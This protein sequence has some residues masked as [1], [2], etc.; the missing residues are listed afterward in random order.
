[1]HVPRLSLSALSQQLSAISALP[2]PSH[3]FD[4]RWE[5]VPVFR[6]LLGQ[7]RYPE[8]NLLF[9]HHLLSFC[10]INEVP[11]AIRYAVAG[12]QEA[13]RSYDGTPHVDWEDALVAAPRGVSRTTEED[14]R[15]ESAQL[16]PVLSRTTFRLFQMHFEDVMA[17][18]FF[19]PQ[20]LKEFLSYHL[21]KQPKNFE[22]LI[23]IAALAY[24]FR[25]FSYRTIEGASA[26]DLFD[27]YESLM[28]AALQY[29]L[30]RDLSSLSLLELSQEYR[31]ID[32]L[33]YF[34]TMRLRTLC[35]LVLPDAGKGPLEK[36]LNDGA[37]LGEAIERC[38]SEITGNQEGDRN[39]QATYDFLRSFGYVSRL[40]SLGHYFERLKND[41]FSR[42]KKVP[43]KSFVQALHQT[44]LFMSRWLM[45]MI[46]NLP[47][48]LEWRDSDLEETIDWGTVRQ[49]Y[50][51]MQYEYSQ[52]LYDWYRDLFYAMPLEPED[53][54]MDLGSGYG[55]LA[56][57]AAI[58][59]PANVIG[60]EILPQRLEVA[61]RAAAALDLGRITFLQ[62]N[63]L[64]ADLQAANVFCLFSS[65]DPQTL[66]DM[67]ERLR[68]ESQRRKGH[69][70]RPMRIVSI[71]NS[72]YF[73]AS[74][75]WLHPRRIIRHEGN[76]GERIRDCQSFSMIFEP[77]V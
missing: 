25:K 19:S 23:E 49:Q 50:G 12:L 13:L 62:G 10:P 3:P 74:Q 52:P 47:D 53:T 4:A 31:R 63:V 48:P 69:P 42:L 1:M 55:A 32:F 11:H 70:G 36:A 66:T 76:Q 35:S 27:R 39:L 2:K 37:T 75:R 30:D 43:A 6:E 8:V 72:N 45:D 67:S 46:L 61:Q 71:G 68:L 65:L 34:T 26:K 15:I 57:Y 22:R 16:G 20:K 5:G 41:L 40:E 18:D 64:Q 58:V 44:D 60:I 38:A 33:Y 73:F 9:R 54:L 17:P 29:A 21:S 14:L 7:P 51:D 28:R 56:I 24:Y 77:R 59:S